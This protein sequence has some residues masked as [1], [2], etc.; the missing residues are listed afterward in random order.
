MNYSETLDYIYKKLPMFSRM[1]SAAFKKDLTNTLALC[2]HL[3][4]PQEKFKS[5]HVAGTNGKGS[6]SHML[7][8]IFQTAGY[9]TGLYTS[10]HL[11]DFRERIKLNGE[12]IAK[13]EVIAFVEDLKPLIERLEP[14]FFEITVAMAFQYF[15]EQNADIVVIEVGLGGRL[16]S[17]NI[18][19]P[20]LS[21]ITNIGWDHMNM[22]GTSLQEIAAEKGGIIKENIPVVIGETLPETKPVF[23]ELAAEKKA[24]VYWAEDVFSIKGQ[25]LNPSSLSLELQKKDGSLLTIET[26][27][28][29]IY[30]VQ[31]VRTVFTA[32]EVIRHL[33]WTVDD[34][35]VRNALK[36]VKQLTGLGGRWEII[37]REPTIVLEVAHNP[38]GIQKMLEHLRQISYHQL[39]IVFGMVKDK[40]AESILKLLPPEATY[41]LTQAHIPRA[42]PAVELA[43]KAEAFGLRGAVYAD[44]NQAL[45]SAKAAAGKDDLIL[46]CGSIFLVAEVD[47]SQYDIWPNRA[48]A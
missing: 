12:M 10:P 16:D 3:G 32:V 24:P 13:E 18:I 29:G 35:V 28:A 14:S 6:V 42:L 1:G 41:Y 4:N 30:Q 27:L 39:H 37:Q 44:V 11:Y 26:D 47:K 43:K 7:A 17:T 2:E 25:Q 21:I 5:I 20:E 33:G 19:T 38:N 22:L 31:N 46:V 40:E 23:E 45:D 9:K 8:A 36:A 15:A 34:T 48:K